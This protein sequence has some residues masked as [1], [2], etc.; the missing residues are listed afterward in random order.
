MTN[1]ID[2]ISGAGCILAIG[3][4]TTEAHPVLAIQVKK[5]VRQ[6][7]KLVVIDPRKTELAELA[8]LAGVWLQP[9]PGTNVALLNGIMKAIIEEDL[10]DQ[11]FVEERTEGFAE[12]RKSLEALDLDWISRITSVPAEKI[13]EAARLFAGT[14]KGCILYAMGITQ[15]TNGVDAVLAVANLGMLTGNVG[16]ENTGVNPLRGQNNVQGA[17][18]M[19]ALHNVYPGYQAVTSPEM[20]AKFEKAWGVGTKPGAVKELSLRAGSTV[21]ETMHAAHEGRVHAMWIMGENPM[22]SDPDINHVAGALKRL[23]FLVVHD[24]FLT[25]TTAFADVVLPAASFAEKSG[26]FTNTERR[27]QRVRKAIEPIGDSKPDWRIIV[28]V[29]RRLGY[30]IDYSSPDEILREA[31]SLTPIYG[32]ILPERLGDQGL[33]WPC[34]T[35]DHPGTRFLHRDGFARGKGLFSTVEFKPAAEVADDEYPFIFTTG[36]ML[37]H[38]HTGTMS[39]RSRPIHKH[40]PDAYLEINPGTAEKLGVKDGDWVEVASRRGSVKVKAEL[41]PGIGPN[42]VFMPFHF[43]EAPANLLTND[44]LDPRAKIPEYKVCAVKVERTDPPEPQVTEPSYP[45]ETEVR[46]G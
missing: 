9:F 36:R 34:P 26:T 18:D 31:A 32:G 25:E 8:E 24:I 21:V 3:T 39:R 30:E 17:C 28:E 23:D 35:P 10:H 19:G 12:F 1:S 45:A 42:V 40:R 29:A 27:V 4:N 6:K 33:Q 2:E 43:S 7:R 37:Y 14:D 46:P 44:A 16:R 38:Y 13:R 11:K 22:L 5:A 20:K 41:E 15:H